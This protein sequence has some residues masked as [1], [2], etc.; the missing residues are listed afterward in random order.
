MVPFNGFIVLQFPVYLSTWFP[1]ILNV[2]HKMQVVICEVKLSGF[3]IY[4]DILRVT[5]RT[6]TVTF[7]NFKHSSFAFF[8]SR[9]GNSFL[10]PLDSR[11]QFS[12]LTIRFGTSLEKDPCP[13]LQYSGGTVNSF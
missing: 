3:V 13:F 2:N 10:Y 8:E 1:P 11:L 12:H 4:A 5:V 9:D 7:A 6:K